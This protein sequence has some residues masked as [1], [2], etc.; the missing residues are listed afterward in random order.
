MLCGQ[1][2]AQGVHAQ[3]HQ[4]TPAGKGRGLRGA[5]LSTLQTGTG[6]G[7]GGGSA[8][9]YAVG[10]Q[11][12]GGVLGVASFTALAVHHLDQ[13]EIKRVEGE[14]AAEIKLAAAEIKRV[15]G[16][17]RLSEERLR[18]EVERYKYDLQLRHTQ[19]YKPYQ[20][21]KEQA[22]KDRGG[23]GGPQKEEETD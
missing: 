11:I 5:F 8:K 1:G 7:S 18:A 10:L 17:R 6:T 2:T 23:T 22:N 12:V 13:R 3:A 15:E 4:Y 20:V 16:E 19:D 14:R 9:E 21:A